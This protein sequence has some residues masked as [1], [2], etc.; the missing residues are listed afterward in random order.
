MTKSAK[1]PRKRS[2][3]NSNLSASHSTKLQR[4]TAENGNLKVTRGTETALIEDSIRELHG[5]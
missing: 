4:P 1:L 2:Q 5:Y 3:S